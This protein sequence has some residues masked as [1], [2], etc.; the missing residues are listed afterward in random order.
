MRHGAA[1]ANP[2]QQLRDGVQIERGAQAL[3]QRSHFDRLIQVGSRHAFGGGGEQ[4]PFERLPGREPCGRVVR[5]GAD[6]QQQWRAGDERLMRCG[7]LDSD[8]TAASARG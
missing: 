2:D 8:Q 5:A 4:H 6:A 1:A 7:G 3:A